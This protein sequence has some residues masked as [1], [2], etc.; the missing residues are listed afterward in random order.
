MGTSRRAIR[1]RVDGQYFVA[2]DNGLHTC[3]QARRST[4]RAV[5]MCTWTSRCTRLAEVSND[6][7]DG[8]IFH[9]R[10][11]L[12]SGLPLEKQAPPDKTCC[13]SN[14]EVKVMQQR[15]WYEQDRRNNFGTFPPNNRRG[16]NKTITRPR[17][18]YRGGVKKISGKVPTFGERLRW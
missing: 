4:R 5:Q 8:D 12:A 3:A 13:S 10:A 6:F 11:Y 18:V 7:H 16:I 14:P 9:G 1:R 15:T 17:C 2:P